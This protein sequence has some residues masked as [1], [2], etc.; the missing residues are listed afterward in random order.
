MSNSSPASTSPRPGR[1]RAVALL[2]ASAIA[3]LLVAPSAS[4]ADDGDGDFSFGLFGRTVPTAGLGRA[5]VA[6]SDG[7]LRVAIQHNSHVGVLALLEDGS[8]DESFG[9]DGIRM[10][11]M[12]IGISANYPVALFERPNGKLLMV[13]NTD[14]L[15]KVA[16]VQLTAAGELDDDFGSGGIRLVYPGTVRNAAYGAT[17]QGDGKVVF[18]GECYDCGPTSGADTWVARYSETGA[19]DPGFGTTGSVVF[20]AV[21]SGTAYDF[22]GAVRIDAFGRIL[23]AGS[24]GNDAAERPYVARRLAANGAADPGFAGSDGI[25]TLTDLAG[26]HATGIAVSPLTYYPIVS[27]GQRSS[28]ATPETCALV[29]LRSTGTLDTT[30]DGDGIRPMTFEEGT[31]LHAVLL[32]SD[33]RIVAVG[34]IDGDL[35]PIEGFFLARLLDDGTLDDSF[36]DDGLRR[37]EF[38]LDANGRDVAMAATLSGGKLVAAGFAF[39]GGAPQ[40]AILRAQIALIFTDGFETSSTAGWLGN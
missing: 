38:D 17:L 4:R 40:V 33:G 35:S 21:E 34:S 24:A 30:F 15:R 10:V 25:R 6:R 31:N 13:A 18:V 7:S 22:G 32:Q 16:L 3:L 27:T 12:T 37:V 11:S 1:F 39:E 14:D 23:L 29:R 19:F 28:S 5:V 8:I 2:G 9:D 26:Q 20:D 36:S